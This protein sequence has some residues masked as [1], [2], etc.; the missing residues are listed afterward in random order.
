[1]KKLSL[2]LLLGLFSCKEE[3]QPEIGKFYSHSFSYLNHPNNP[4]V[5]I[6]MDTVKVLD[7]KEVYVLYQFNNGYKR[8][9]EI[10]WFNK[11]TRKIE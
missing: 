5:T 7:A 6:S 1:M 3:K 2:V 11:V 10:R 9:D 8:S 4:F